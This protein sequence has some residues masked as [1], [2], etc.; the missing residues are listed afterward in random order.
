MLWPLK[1]GLS[2]AV[3]LL[4]SSQSCRGAVEGCTRFPV[5]GLWSTQ[6]VHWGFD[7]VNKALW[8]KGGELFPPR[9]QTLG[10]KTNLTVAMSC[11]LASSWPW[12]ISTCSFRLWTRMTC[13]SRVLLSVVAC[14]A[15]SS[16]F[17]STSLRLP[18]STSTLWDTSEL[19]AA[20]PSTWLLTTSNSSLFP[21]SVVCRW[22]SCSRDTVVRCISARRVFISV[23]SDR[24]W[25]G[26][27]DDLSCSAVARAM[28]NCFWASEEDSSRA[29]RRVSR[30]SERCCWNET[31][32]S[33]VKKSWS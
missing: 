27:S 3:C 11:A 32:R 8:V 12:H 21:F 5:A 2:K 31:Y 28:P 14:P 9:L 24:T 15:R 22:L 4:F 13:A 33:N 6:T 29:L 23:W 19:S 18:V 26:R 17:D 1:G 25:A 20:R 16:H 30:L 10:A 7:K